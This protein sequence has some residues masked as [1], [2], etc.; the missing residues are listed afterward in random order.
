V[1]APYCAYMSSGL[2]MFFSDLPILPNSRVTGWPCQV[3]TVRRRRRGAPAP[4]RPGPAARGV[5]VGRGL[6]VALVEAV[7]KGSSCSG[8]PGRA[9]PCART[10]HRAG[11]AP[12]ARHHR[13]TGRRHPGRGAGRRAG[14]ALGARAHPVRLVPGRPRV[15]VAPGRGSA[16]STSTSRPSWAWCWSR[17]EASGAAAVAEVELDLHPVGARASGGSGS[18]LSSSGSKVFGL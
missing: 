11:A 18:E 7:R 14:D 5:A 12:R 4:P 17:A 10:G 3:K 9:A 6:D 8:V 16:G 2:T 15:L 1:S 13:R